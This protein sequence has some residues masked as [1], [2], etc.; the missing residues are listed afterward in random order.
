MTREDLAV[1]VELLGW[2]GVCLAVGLVLTIVAHVD[3]SGDPATGAGSPA[4]RSRLWRSLVVVGV[5][6][7]LIALVL[8]AWFHV[9]AA[10]M[11]PV[12]PV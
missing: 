3:R 11:E 1:D 6:A 2:S 9:G 12:T 10:I 7:I 5:A 8:A 4:G